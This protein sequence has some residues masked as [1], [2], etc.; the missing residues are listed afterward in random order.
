M[1]N[2]SGFSKLNLN[3]GYS[4]SAKDMNNIMNKNNGDIVQPTDVNAAILADVKAVN[5]VTNID[6]KN[7]SKYM[8]NRKQIDKD[9][10]AKF[11]RYMFNFIN[12]IILIKVLVPKYVFKDIIKNFRNLLFSTSISNAVIELIIKYI[13]N[14]NNLNVISSEGKFMLRDKSSKNI[15]D[16]FYTL[17]NYANKRNVILNN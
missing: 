3:K 9:I 5:D 15:E 1:G 12:F 10:L 16:L 17:V 4:T 11:D 14:Y 6:I 7:I 8:I 13:L 2:W